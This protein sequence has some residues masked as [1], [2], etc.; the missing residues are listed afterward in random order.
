VTIR[1][2]KNLLNI[3]ECRFILL[4]RSLWQIWISGL[5]R[6]QIRSYADLKSY[7]T[8]V[9]GMNRDFVSKYNAPALELSYDRLIAEPE[10][11]LQDLCKFL[12]TELLLK[13]LE[14]IYHNPLHTAPKASLPDTVRALL[15]YGKNYSER[16]DGPARRPSK[17]PGIH[18]L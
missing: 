7:E 16:T 4:K 5:R 10:D 8:A 18:A 6:R 17:A 14:A 2:W 1:F 11:T 12:D 9:L 13:H 3:G 15:I